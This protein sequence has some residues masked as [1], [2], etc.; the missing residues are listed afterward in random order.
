MV[1]ERGVEVVGV[2]DPRRHEGEHADRQRLGQRL[3]D[4][5]LVAL[6]GL[7]RVGEKLDPEADV[8]RLVAVDVGEALPEPGQSIHLLQAAEH[9]PGAGER[10][11]A[12]D[13]DHVD[14]DPA[15]Q[16]LEVRRV[17]AQFLGDV[18]EDAVE[19][20]AEIVVDVLP[21]RGQVVGDRLRLDPEH[22]AV[23][24]VEEDDV[25][26][27]VGDLRGEE[28]PLIV[29]R[30]SDREREQLGRHPLLA[31]EELR[32]APDHVSLLLVGPRVAVPLLRRR[33]SKSKTSEFHPWRSQREISF[34]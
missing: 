31:D 34:R 28:D 27:L 1:A 30:R 3:L 21:R 20:L 22:L 10:Q 5:L 16:G 23:I 26:R 32:Q 18:V 29:G 12:L 11:G 15:D 19:E 7:D 33:A 6:V 8:T 24:A 9:E 25:A 13:D 4:D 14:G 17:L 2:L